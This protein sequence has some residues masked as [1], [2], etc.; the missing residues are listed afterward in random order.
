MKIVILG[1]GNIAHY[2]CTQLSDNKEF[3]IIQ[4]Y[5]RDSQKGIVFQ[6]KFNIPVVHNIN[7][8]SL[9]AD[10]YIFAIKD[11]AISSLS[12]QINRENAIAI[13]CAGSQSLNLLEQTSKRNAIIWPIYSINK[14]SQYSSKIPL[15]IDASAPEVEKDVMSLAKAVSENTQI[16]G[17]DQRQY[18]HLNAVLVNNFSNHLFSIAERLS[19]EHHLDFEILKPI[20]QQTIQNLNIAK[21]YEMQTGPAKR[22]D[23]IT[24]EKHLELID[25]HPEWQNLYKTLSTSIQLMY[26]IEKI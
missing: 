19:E 15:I 23:E 5:G 4:A 14:Q 21:P 22:H 16:V 18:L 1:L 9:D 11:N 7:D 10:I 20:I 2:F 26:P 25:N 3:K 24:M 8:L 17:F 12:S 13:H 6:N